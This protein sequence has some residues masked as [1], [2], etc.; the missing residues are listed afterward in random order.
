MKL[1]ENVN[2]DTR[3]PY[4]KTTPI[5]LKINM[6]EE[7]L[8]IAGLTEQSMLTPLKYIYQLGLGIRTE[9]M[10][11]IM[12]SVIFFDQLETFKTISIKVLNVFWKKLLIHA[13][14]AC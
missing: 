9:P 14:F 8:R 13:F 4:K 11:V 7:E 5:I 6:H 2:Y 3:M 12:H 1:S 10:H